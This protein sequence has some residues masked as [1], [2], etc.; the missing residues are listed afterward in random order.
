MEKLKL[1]L[2]VLCGAQQLAAQV[3]VDGEWHC[4]EENGRPNED[5]IRVTSTPPGW[6]MIA[7]FVF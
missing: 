3:A 1:E 5:T 7:L 2:L 6:S 4:E